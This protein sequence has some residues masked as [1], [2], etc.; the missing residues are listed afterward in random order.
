MEIQ[1]PYGGDSITCDLPLRGEQVS[2]LKAPDPEPTQ[3]LAALVAD[4]LAHPFGS[5]RLADMVDSSSKVA[6]IFEDWTRNTPVAEIMPF[7]L[8]ELKA[9]G[10]VDERIILACGNGMHDPVYMNEE[11]MIQKLGDKVF[12][13]YRIVSHDAYKPEA[14][15][16]IGVSRCLG[17]PLFIN[18]EVAEADIKI[19]VGKIAP[20][21]DVGYSGGSKM[22]MPGVS[23]LWSIIHHHTGSY[24][25][26]GTLDNFLRKDIEECGRMAGL[27]FIVNAVANSQGQVMR[28]FAGEPQAAHR[29]GVAYGDREV[30][31]AKIEEPADILICWPG[32]WAEDYFMTSLKCLGITHTCLKEDASVVLVASCHKGWSAPEYL[33]LCWHVDKSLLEYDYPELWRLMVT[34]AYHEPHK[35][36]QAL[37]YFV[38]HIAKTCREK[39]VLL[40]GAKSVCAEEMRKLDIDLYE[41]VEQALKDAVAKQGPGAKA[42]V[43]PDC[44]TLPLLKFHTAD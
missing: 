4:A 37:V 12:R 28:I 34:R 33:E 19:A 22:I 44:F 30:W 42:L 23:D 25:H 39:N 26:K 20:H 2:F 18:R 5:P 9:G 29:Q 6:I 41:S 40:A 7:L 10:V 13:K 3:D 1:I 15:T 14:L 17:T 24:P 36:F 32:P 43:V 27:N 16:F 31:G 11:R 8:E 38:Q 35:Q 21:A